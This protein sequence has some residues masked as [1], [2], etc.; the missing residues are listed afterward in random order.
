MGRVKGFKHSK[1]TKIKIGEAHKDY[2]H[3]EETKQK[4]R[5]II[6][7]CGYGFQ[8]GE[9]SCFFGKH[10]TDISKKK[11]GMAQIGNKHPWKGGVSTKEGY[12]FIFFPDHPFAGQ[13]KYVSEHRLI[14]ESFIG[15]YLTPKEVVHHINGIR[16]DNRI[17]N[18]ILF[19]NDSEHTN[20][21][22]NLRK[23][24]V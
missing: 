18:L 8:K 7:N 10:H 6:N 1:E 21:H 24:K 2:K 3:T 5:E 12:T 13:N 20:Y 15:R 19:A 14:M 16:D 23:F 4:L 22:N 9:K 11:I 17:E